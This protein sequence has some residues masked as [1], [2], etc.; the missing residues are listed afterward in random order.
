MLLL[1]LHQKS[2]RYGALG[3]SGFMGKPV[4]LKLRCDYGNV[5]I[6]IMQL[7]TCIPIYLFIYLFI[8]SF[9]HSFFCN[10]LNRDVKEQD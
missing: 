10:K 1:K 9:V 8:H 6:H 3:D 7:N 2:S 5:N 4:F